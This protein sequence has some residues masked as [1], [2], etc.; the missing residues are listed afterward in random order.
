MPIRIPFP[1]VSSWELSDVH[2]VP[3]PA[4]T[5]DPTAPLA[6]AENAGDSFPSGETEGAPMWEYTVRKVLTA[7]FTVTDTYRLTSRRLLLLQRETT[8]ADGAMTFTPDP[9]LTLVE[10]ADGEGHTWRSAGV[11]VETGTAMVI[12]GL[13][14][15]REPVDVCGTMHDAYRVVVTERM[16][17]LATGD[18][19][20]TAEGD[21]NV[22]HVASQLGGL[23]L[24]EDLHF[25]Q[26]ITT[27]DGPA[28]VEW[29]YVSTQDST[30]PEPMP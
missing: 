18:T 4:V 26:A 11:D 19:S 8:T 20:G 17:N 16:V 14:E 25:T 24:R 28:V 21:A 1:R 22:Y 9:P 15:R 7:E 3:A 23:V 12:D 10:H 5:E 29:E 6:G 27:A 2:E 30:E 13:V